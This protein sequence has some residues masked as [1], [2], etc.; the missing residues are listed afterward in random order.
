MFS[1]CYQC[2]MPRLDKIIDPSGPFA[3]CPECGYKQPFLQLPLMLVGGAS[4]A[5][6]SSVCHQL[7]GRVPQAVVLDSDIIWN[8]SYDTPETGFRAFF[9]AWLGV[10]SSIGQSGRPV[11]GFGGGLGV[12]ENIEN[13][14][15]RRYFTQVHYLALVCS[16]EVLVRRLQQRPAWRGCARPEFI[17]LQ[18]RFNNW[19]K[20]YT[21]HPEIKLLDTTSTPLEE[22]V[23][24]VEN[25][26]NNRIK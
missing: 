24:K 21:G 10:C 25:W 8:A 1:I 16:E 14:V 4:C 5:G 7:L 11:V 19:F 22:T 18:V 2:G 20:T 23:Q 13:C 3:T 15:G 17:D 9:E 6:K 12:P 26:I